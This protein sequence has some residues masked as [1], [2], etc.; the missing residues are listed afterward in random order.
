MK[1]INVENACNVG[2]LPKELKEKCVGI[3]NSSLLGAV[4]FAC[5][6]N[7]LSRY[8]ENAKYVDL[9]ANSTFA[10]LFVDNMEF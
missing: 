8:L 2:L 6:Q 1:K 5:E 9:S 3:N 4:K 7:D 10:E